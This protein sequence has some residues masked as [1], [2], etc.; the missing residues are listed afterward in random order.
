M[1]WLRHKSIIFSSTC[2]T[3]QKFHMSSQY[4][5]VRN[6]Q[7]RLCILENNR[8]I[9]HLIWHFCRSQRVIFYS[10]GSQ[11]GLGSGDDRA[12]RAFGFCV[13][14]DRRFKSIQTDSWNRFTFFQML[15]VYPI[16][17]PLVRPETALVDGNS[18]EEGGQGRH[19]PDPWQDGP[20]C[21]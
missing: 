3:L 12:N 9:W 20:P 14:A 1:F 6:L 8:K 13:P 10:N 4:D 17:F 19:N 15:P 16:N 18:A 7:M 5:D 21:I 2:F 11:G